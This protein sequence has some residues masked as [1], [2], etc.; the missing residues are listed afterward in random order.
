MKTSMIVAASL[1]MVSLPATAQTPASERQADAPMYGTV[2]S[3]AP[4]YLHRAALNYAA[5]L[6]SECDGVVE[7]AI[8]HSTLLR[9][10]AQDLEM[11]Q[12][13]STLADLAESGRTPAIR[14]KAYLAAAV[15]D[16]PEKFASTA[17]VRYADSEEFFSAVAS[18]VH[19]TL[20]GHNAH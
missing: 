1:L 19:R 18:Q 5:A 8:A 9:M 6:R 13:Q 20:L 17:K 2:Y 10:V 12:I 14:Y 3:Y 16:N 15:F 7:S 11:T 4:S